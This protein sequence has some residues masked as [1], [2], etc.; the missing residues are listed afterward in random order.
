[1]FC[2]VIQNYPGIAVPSNV[3]C[4]LSPHIYLGEG[5]STAR[6]HWWVNCIHAIKQLYMHSMHRVLVLVL[7]QLLMYMNT[8]CNSDI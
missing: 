6:Q 4:C 2:S 3:K 7:C 5:G 1:M 8:W